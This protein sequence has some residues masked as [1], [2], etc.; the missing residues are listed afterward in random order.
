VS[1]FRALGNRL[2]QGKS[3]Y[4]LALLADARGEKQRATDYLTKSREIFHSLGARL[5]E[6]RAQERFLASSQGVS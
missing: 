5:E 2:E 1:L 4:E 6:T 3:F